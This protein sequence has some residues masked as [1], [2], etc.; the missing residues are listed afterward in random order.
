[1]SGPFGA[2]GLQLFG[3][4]GDFYPYT[5]DQSLRFEDGDNPYLTKTFSSSGGTIW[6][7]S[8]WV[9]LGTTATSRV[10]LHG[11]SDG[12]NFAQLVLDSNAEVAFYSAT[13]G[14]ARILAHTQA[15]QRD[16][17]AWYHIV[18]K[19]NA[20]SGSEEY[21]VYVNGE[22]QTL[23]ITTALS[24]HQSK[25]GNN[26]ANYI[27]NNF[28]QSLDFDGYMA[29]VNFIDGTAL[30]ADSFGETKAGIWIPKQ[31]SGS[32]GTNGFYL[33]FADGSALGDDESGNANDFTASGLASTDVVLD[34]PTNNFGTLNPLATDYITPPNYAEGNLEFISVFN[35]HRTV[36]GSMGL[37]TGKWYFEG[38]SH[39]GNKFTIGLSD[40]LNMH[41]TQSS[42]ANNIIG[43]LPSGLYAYGDAVGLY[44]G[45]I[46]KNGSSV[47]SSLGYAT[48]DKMAIA[49]DADAGKVWFRRNGTWFNGSG[50]DSTTLD[51][52]N[53]DTTVTTG[54]TYVP[55]FSA[56]DPTGW[57]VN[58]GQ[59]SSFAGTETAQG[60]TDENGQGD[61][62]YSV[63]SGF[64]ALCSANLPNP[65]IDPA[66]DEEPADYFNTVLYTG[67]GSAPL[68]ITGVGFQ[69]DWIWLKRR[70]ATSNHHLFNSV[71]GTD[72][73]LQASTS[74]AE[75]TGSNNIDSFDSDG[76]TL[77]AT[78]ATNPAENNLNSTDV[79]WNW[80][81]G[82]SA[83][84][85]TNGSIASSVS[86]NTEA[87]FSIITYTGNSSAATIGHGLSSAPEMYIIK[88]TASDNWVVY[89]KD[90]TSASY[91]LTLDTTN[92]EISN[93]VVFNGTDPTSSVLS[94]G[95]S[96]STNGNNFICYAFHS[97]NG[98]SKVG[99]Y[100]GNGSS[101]GSVIYLGFRP[102][103]VMT[104]RIDSTGGWVI[105]DNKRNTHNL[106]NN[107]LR[108]DSS[109][110]E[111]TANIS[112][113]LSN[114]FKLRST[115]HNESGSSYI[116]LAFAEQPFKYSNAR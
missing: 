30:D 39:G 93:N 89:H 38:R 35:Y 5:I 116:Y 87:G 100:T 58:F 62:F 42:T 76:F 90:L 48:G 20:T 1:M 67:T 84:S 47:A 7:F 96:R 4:A 105:V 70:S 115:T 22:N 73:F 34:S 97:V 60:N 53:H 106:V 15:L 99:S 36:F 108:P 55:A 41:H 92:Q 85:N 52:N 91:Y 95:T 11:Y 37:T 9:K 8:C 66:K 16:P 28:N 25:I 49:F 104:K 101:A 3:G 94:V 59:D 44:A 114:G 21:K 61:F 32:Y 72:K 51:P 43:Y 23:D 103:W 17:S 64:L 112:D 113:F 24:A 10:L 77:N 63:P 54:E 111:L 78:S 69:P 57:Y 27:G 45:T 26:N 13:S 68:A 107:Y 33:D 109:T 79:A 98:Y 18:A 40:A 75:Q 56:E 50:T 12:N 86:A 46:Y 6:T 74:D 2:G 65:A 110:N 31:Y 14:T 102:S 29:E 80:L 82:G 83:V 88:N 81:A 19:F 71:R